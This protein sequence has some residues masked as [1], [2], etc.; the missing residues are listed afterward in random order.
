[1]G[2]G[3]VGGDVHLAPARSLPVDGLANI[4]YFEARVKRRAHCEWF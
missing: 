3:G 2:K 4:E 1:M